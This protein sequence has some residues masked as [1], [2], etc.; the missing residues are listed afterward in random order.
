MRKLL[1]STLVVGA[2]AALVVAATALA[3]GSAGAAPTAIPGCAPGSLN[4]V[5]DGVLTAGADNPAFPPWFGGA[6]KTKPWK[7]SD[8][9]SGKGYESAVAYTVA[10]ELGFTKA[11]VKW[12]VVPFN[13]SFRPGKK[14][15]DFYIT[16]V[17]FTP[18]RARAVDFSNSYYFVNQAVVGRKGQPIAKVKSI[19]GLRPYKLGAQVG[20]T[21]YTYI[22]RYIRPSSKPLVYDTNDAA[23]QA[24]KN[25]QID[26]IV[27]DLPTAFYVTAVQVDDGVI[28][29]KLPTRG[30]KERFGMVFEKGNTLR[31]CVNRALDRLWA[32]GTIK[33]LQ[34][35][36]LARAGAPDIT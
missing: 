22:T 1:T 28:V 3:A 2:T 30:T 24:L 15:F 21:S 20:T 11:Q 25:G 8:P 12:T 14:P 7:V 33:K 6:Q 32:N 34:T 4:L 31:R 5:E 27:V 19:A 9:Y 18:E 10:R 17:S 26:G 16:Q 36:Y 23:V 35:T 13:N 29:G